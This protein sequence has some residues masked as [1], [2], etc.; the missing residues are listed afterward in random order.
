[1]CSESVY[2]G[3]HDSNGVYCLRLYHPRACQHRGDLASELCLE[4]TLLYIKSAWSP[5]QVTAYSVETHRLKMSFI[6]IGGSKTHAKL[7]NHYSVNNSDKGTQLER[8]R[9]ALHLKQVF[10]DNN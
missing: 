7:G 4:K 5:E 2:L 10:A 9:M 8:S 3:I 6:H 1:M